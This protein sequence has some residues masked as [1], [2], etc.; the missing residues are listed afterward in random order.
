MIVKM[1][2][3]SLVVLNKERKEALTQLKKV[4]V[5]HLEQVEGK[6]EQLAAFKEASNNAMVASS[7]LGEIKLPKK[8]TAAA[9]L[10]CDEVA[11]KCR[12]VLELS[13]KK[14]KLMEEISSDSAEIESRCRELLR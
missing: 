1:K 13:E 6:G 14:K 2:K 10:S 12:E 9:E 8:H 11:A 4:G 7:I 5:V 3:V